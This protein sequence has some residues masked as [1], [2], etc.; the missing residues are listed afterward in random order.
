MVSIVVGNIIM[1]DFLEFEGKR[2]GKRDGSMRSVH[3]R[4]RDRRRSR[5]TRTRCFLRP[6]A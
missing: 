2:E 5:C 6:F 4:K 3:V 1:E